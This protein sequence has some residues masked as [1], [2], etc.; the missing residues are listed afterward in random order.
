MLYHV[1]VHIMPLEGLLDPAGK[2]T[3]HSLQQLQM[4][5]VGDVR[6]G[7]RIRLA[8][9]APTEAAARTLAEEAAQRLLANPVIE[10]Y[11]IGTV[12]Q[13]QPA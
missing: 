5:S 2:A 4:A 8:V 10:Y 1:Y 7:K 11:E 12:A 9:E 13:A 6:I 3:Q